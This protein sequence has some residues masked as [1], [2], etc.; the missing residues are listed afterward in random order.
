MKYEKPEVEVVKFE[1]AG[2]MTASGNYS[3]ADEMLRVL[4]GDNYSGKT[5]N[6]NCSSFGGVT[7]PSNGTTIKVGD[8]YFTSR[9]NKNGQ[10][11]QLCSDYQP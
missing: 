5:N 8:Y 6:F 1:D 7:N 2:F 4:L 9:G 3:S 10:H 11:W